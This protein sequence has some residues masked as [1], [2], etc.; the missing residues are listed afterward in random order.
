MRRSPPGHDDGPDGP[1]SEGPGPDGRGDD[2]REV[3]PPGGPFGAAQ[4]PTFL[5]VLEVLAER[6]LLRAP[7]PPSAPGLPRPE[8]G[9]DPGGADGADDSPAPARCG[10]ALH[11]HRPAPV[12]PWSVVVGLDD[13]RATPP[14]EEARRTEPGRAETGRTEA[15]PRPGSRTAHGPWW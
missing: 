7:D 8:A 4:E 9:P 5:R 15:R 13:D 6:G 14:P 11:R 2:A 1:G 3:G 12:R 10:C